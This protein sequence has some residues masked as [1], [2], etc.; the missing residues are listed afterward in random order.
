V[1]RAL[2]VHKI[3]KT[4]FT[5]QED[6][7]KLTKT[8]AALALSTSLF[9]PM[10][11]ADQPCGTYEIS[12]E[13]QPCTQVEVQPPQAPPVP[14][15]PEQAPAPQAV[16]APLPAQTTAPR[17]GLGLG[18]GLRSRYNASGYQ[19]PRL[20]G[21]LQNRRAENPAQGNSRGIELGVRGNQESDSFETGSLQFGGG[22]YLRAH[23]R[24]GQ[25]RLALELSADIVENE[26]LGLGA[27]MLYLNPQ[28]IVKPFALGGGGVS[29]DS[30]SPIWQAGAGVDVMISPRFT[31]SADLRGLE[32]TNN[33]LELECDNTGCF[34]TF[35][36]SSY[37]IG[38]VGIARKF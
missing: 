35:E 12:T 33:R 20:G 15:A 6:L 26:L 19:R 2:L 21:L 38:N 5:T 10:A 25:Q 36:F 3:R 13:Q 31:V 28:G 27:L 34:E 30:E 37:L 22:L 11:L 16:Y 9:A 4:T 18:L 7:M 32:A 17:F 29:F 1:A 23:Q 8:T 14:C 24:G